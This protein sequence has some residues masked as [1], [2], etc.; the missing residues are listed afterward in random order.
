[1]NIEA[2]RNRIL[3]KDESNGYIE[4]ERAIEEFLAGGGGSLPQ[5][6]KYICALET[7]L[8]T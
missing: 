3:S 2:F 8:G 5:A 7:V 1:M 4:R 6:Q